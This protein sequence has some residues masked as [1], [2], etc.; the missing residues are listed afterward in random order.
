MKIIKKNQK[1]P[2][3]HNIIDTSKSEVSAFEKSNADELL[4]LALLRE[5][6]IITDEEFY[7][8]KAKLLNK[9]ST[10]QQ[11]QPQ[12]QPQHIYI[13]Q[14]QQQQQQQQQKQGGC[15]GSILK[16]IG[17]LVVVLILLATCTDN[18][19]Q[20]TNVID[21]TN[22]NSPLLDKAKRQD[23]ELINT[24]SDLGIETHN[25]PSNIAKQEKLPKEQA[26]KESNNENMNE[27]T[28]QEKNSNIS[29]ELF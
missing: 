13:T 24:T 15:L 17:A 11:Q 26:L 7:I 29:N 5:K 4:K 18:K 8:E 28:N 12:S 27:L 2:Q 16:A 20:N 6:Q 1:K 22:N 3:E 19:K 21:N 23:I 25:T 14:N 9:F 10:P